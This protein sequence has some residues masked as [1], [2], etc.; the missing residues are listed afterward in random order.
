M[1]MG[2][3][4][5]IAELFQDEK[6]GATWFHRG[7]YNTLSSIATDFDGYLT[8]VRPYKKSDGIKEAEQLISTLYDPSVE[9]SWLK[10]KLGFGSTPHEYSFEL[11]FSEGKLRFIMKT[12]TSNEAQEL[13]KTIGGIYPHAQVKDSERHMPKIPEQSY[14]AGGEF[15]LKY[16]KYAPLR[17]FTGPDP[18]EVQKVEES[19]Q[20]GTVLIDPYK[21]VASELVGHKSEAVMLQITF[22]S[23]PLNWTDG[24]GPM[25]PSAERKAEYLK[26]G[27]SV[28]SLKN[29]RIIDPTEKDLRTAEH[30]TDLEDSQAFQCNIRYFVWDTSEESAIRRTQAIENI[31][32]NVYQNNKVAQ[33]FDPVRYSAKDV[34]DCVFDAARRK[35][36]RKGVILTKEEVA[37]LAHFPN[38]TIN[39]ANVDFVESVFGEQAPGD[40]ATATKDGVIESSPDELINSQYAEVNEHDPENGSDDSEGRK[41]P[42]D[43]AKELVETNSNRY[44]KSDRQPDEYVQT[45][46]TEDM[47][48]EPTTDFHELAAMFERGDIGYDYFY[49]E[50]ESDEKADEIIEWVETHIDESYLIQAYRVSQRQAEANGNKDSP[51]GSGVGEDENGDSDLIT[52]DDI[53][54][55]EDN[56]EY[57]PTTTER[58]KASSKANGSKA[59]TDGA[60]AT[61]NG[62][63][64]EEPEY[65][66]ARQQKH[67]V[68]FA[69]TEFR[70]TRSDS[71]DLL[72]M[73]FIQKDNTGTQYLGEDCRKLFIEGHREKKD[74]DIWLGYQEQ[75][76]NA[77]R[78]V[79]VPRSAWFQHISMFGTTGKGKSTLMK[80]MA[81][82]VAHKGHGFVIIDPKG[83]MAKDLMKE[84]PEDRLDDVIWVEPGSI[85]HDKIAA[86]NFLETSVPKDHPRYDRE[87]ES[88]VSD[89][90]AVLRAGEYWGPKMAGITK[91]ITRAMVRSEN[92]YTLY[93]MYNVLIREDKRWNFARS[94][95]RE[96]VDLGT[97]ESGDISE[98]VKQYSRRIAEMDDDEVDPVVR[99]LQ[100]WAESPISKEIVSHRYSTVSIDKA[101]NE[102]KIILVKNSVEDRE[103]KRVISTAIMRRVWVAIQA[104]AEATEEEADREPYFAF[105]DEFD[106]VV[107][108]DMEIDK[109]LSKAR[110]GRM[111]VTLATQNPSQ[112]KE[113]Y[114]NILKQIFNN[115]ETMVSFAVRDP[116]DGYL[117]SKR[118]GEDFDSTDM[119]N[120]PR[121]RVVTRVSYDGENGPQIS[122]PLGLRTFP[123]YP[124]LRTRSQ[125]KKAIKDSLD[126][127][128]VMPMDN[129]PGET[130]LLISGG[131]LQE[132]TVVNFLELVW[133]EH[134][135]SRSE[136]VEVEAVADRFEEIAGE[137]IEHYPNGIAIPEELIT[138]H[139]VNLDEDDS[140]DTGYF[141]EPEHFSDKPGGS[142]AKS[143]SEDV[144]ESN[145]GKIAYRSNGRI[146]IQKNE[147]QVSITPQGIDAVL[148][149]DTGRSQ[150][151]E[152]HREIIRQSIR[153]FSRI[154]FHTH[155]PVQ[156]GTNRV[157]DAQAD[158]PITDDIS[159]SEM[160]S[161]LDWFADT[162]P[163][164]AEFSQTSNINI[165]AE[166]TTQN[167]PA[168]TI[169]NVLRAKR[170]GRR[171][172]LFVKDGREDGHGRDF[173]AHRVENILTDPPYY[174]QKRYIPPGVDP[175]Q[176]D[177]D[178]DPDEI[179]FL[180]NKASKLK[181][182][183]PDENQDKFAL[184][185]AGSQTVWMDMGDHLNLYDGRGPDA[186]KRGEVKYSETEYASSNAMDIWCRYDNYQKEWV[187]YPGQ[188]KQFRY[189]S[190][191]AMEE[192]YQFVY[193]PLYMEAEV[194]ELPD[195]DSWDILILPDPTAITTDPNAPRDKD[196]NAEV[197]IEEKYKLD[198]CF[199]PEEVP[200]L[201]EDGKTTPLIPEEYD[202]LLTESR[203]DFS[204]SD[205]GDT[206]EQTDAS[207]VTTETPDITMDSFD[208]IEMEKR[209][210]EIIDGYKKQLSHEEKR[211]L[212]EF[213]QT[214]GAKNPGV[215]EFWRSVWDHYERDYDTGI[216]ETVLPDAIRSATGL[217]IDK[218]RDAVTIGKDFDLLIPDEPTEPLDIDLG[219]DDTIL[220]LVIP[221]ERPDLYVDDAEQFA[222]KRVWNEVWGYVFAE[223][224]ESLNQAELRSTIKTISAP[225]T[226]TQAD[227][228]IAVG[229]LSGAIQDQDT[230]YLLSGERPDEFWLDI[231]DHV[232]A[233]I[234]SALL[235]RKVFRGI[236]LETDLNRDEII[237][238]FDDAIEHNELY[239]PEHVDDDHYLINDPA[240]DDGPE[241][242]ERDEPRLPDD[243]TDDDPDSGTGRT[244]DAST[245]SDQA[246]HEEVGESSGQA[247]PETN[248]EEPDA[249]TDEPPEPSTPTASE[250]NTSESGDTGESE[251]ATTEATE[252]PT[253]ESSDQ[254]DPTHADEPETA[255]TEAAESPTEESSDQDDQTHTVESDAH[256]DT[257][258]GP[259]QSSVETDGGD[260][261]EILKSVAAENPPSEERVR[262]AFADGIEFFHS[263]LDEPINSNKQWNVDNPDA[264]QSQPETAREYFQHPRYD[265]GDTNPIQGFIN[266]KGLDTADL[267]NQVKSIS[268]TTRKEFNDF[269]PEQDTPP[270]LNSDP[271]GKGTDDA[272]M[273]MMP[274]AFQMRQSRGWSPEIIDKKKLGW[275][276]TDPNA[277]YD[278]LSEKG[279]TDK[280]LVATGLFYVNGAPARLTA[281]FTG[282]YVFPYFNAEGTPVYAI[283][284]SIDTSRDSFKSVDSTYNQKY[285]KTIKN[286]AYSMADE[287]IYG[288]ESVKEGQPVLITEGMADAISAHERGIPCISPV[289]R[290]FKTEH[291]DILKDIILEN[292]IPEV[293]IIQD[294]D[295]ALV[296]DKEQDDEADSISEVLKIGQYGSGM[297]GA[298]DT[299]RYLDKIAL[300]AHEATV[301][302][303]DEKT[304]SGGSGSA[305]E[306]GESSES[307]SVDNGA[308]TEAVPAHIQE[309]CEDDDQIEA[310]S[311]MV[312]EARSGTPSRA[313]KTYIIPLPRFG[314]IKYDLDDYLTDKFGI[315]T[316]PALW[317]ANNTI[318]G[319]QNAQWVNDL[320]ADRHFRYFTGD[321]YRALAD[322]DFENDYALPSA[323]ILNMLPTIAPR[324]LPPEAGSGKGSST[325]NVEDRPDKDW[326]SGSNL[327]DTNLFNIS[328]FDV[329][330]L[331]EGFRGKSPL[332]HIG[333]SENYFC[334]LEDDGAYCHK[335]D[336]WYNPAT[337]ILCLEGERPDDN[338]YGSFSDEEKFA[339]WEHVRNHRIKW[340]QIPNDALIYYAIR[341]GIATEDDVIEREGTYG[342]FNALRARKYHEVVDHLVEN[343][344]FE[345]VRDIKRREDEDEDE[346]T[347]DS[348]D[349]SD[350]PNYENRAPVEDDDMVNLR[351]V[352]DDKEAYDE[353]MEQYD[354]VG[355]ADGD[356]DDEGELTRFKTYKEPDLENDDVDV[357]RDAVKQFVDEFAEIGEEGDIQMKTAS[358]EMLDLFTTW[359]KI[360]DIELDKLSEDTADNF[361]KG[362]L[363]KSLSTLFDVEKVRARLDGE[364]MPLYRPIE[365]S[366]EIKEIRM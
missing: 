253:E 184:M 116:D 226:E 242:I 120:M 315:V 178:D 294:A 211:R 360:N 145:D 46:I 150:P 26:E 61:A 181:V 266:P 21:T 292:N 241:L 161:E 135:R 272:D 205:D 141:N 69:E 333:D 51:R 78:E 328:M 85:E 325:P 337:A 227:A 70:Q 214:F 334:V 68:K 160:Q 86:I 346:E 129:Y 128:G 66:P 143:D 53:E 247:E 282:R 363:K 341:E 348:V 338:P 339:L 96:D 235:K 196:K 230:G 52:L 101:V 102:G 12:P 37:A 218:A 155:L 336:A 269:I 111:S 163:L 172:T 356:E 301:A 259:S 302:H 168:R 297:D 300:D 239:S 212:Q 237:D 213:E 91:N 50:I 28:D 113:D 324:N 330:G 110:S 186:N 170:E 114:P 314:G 279:Y 79:G 232:G 312:D 103:I 223:P 255:T 124:P 158:I 90:Q 250:A 7:D 320:H 197:D 47:P 310:I 281:Q 97:S 33:Q 35:I 27:R 137:A 31:I 357:D 11:W 121:F 95:Q 23:V 340:A 254:E 321:N 15:E 117:I 246:T 73:N 354:Q 182:G 20:V 215:I 349:D 192:D 240:S 8:R 38:D 263:K 204:D 4:G 127:Y 353:T 5:I 220:R 201:Y 107:S 139:N 72:T 58:L 119:T 159:I 130:D 40:S 147:A 332:G 81:L 3:R 274:Y 83:D 25:D 200:L 164:A 54:A 249:E 224:D 30:I 221:E 100:D 142:G 243:D 257:N 84:L 75:G 199:P 131:G 206:D 234:D 45:S 14:V 88:I 327:G 308:S 125:A 352:I 296:H 216:P 342:K 157:C 364:K 64:S 229:V 6:Y 359:A 133:N 151:T 187:V 62:N 149:Q 162:Y 210:R 236:R 326:N 303:S 188:N 17:S 207:N 317:A 60:G 146:Y 251:A 222:D 132:Q 323:T 183:N 270:I 136:I 176:L 276:P 171:A 169:E 42:Y 295:P 59:A 1:N 49:S 94:L 366:D 261:A 319:E 13:Q 347:S 82:Q 108:D 252:S 57:L 10:K 87:V 335:R 153:W 355:S 331:S 41:S 189:E 154:G 305:E 99:R 256:V 48:P 275:A 299:A 231:W 365:L 123:D 71:G 74:M 203:A 177:D 278:H 106:D 65:L 361:R 350:E 173:H 198:F 273:L 358:N 217:T 32:T 244:D 19:E 209:A 16:T 56:P 43:K 260:S 283:S 233:E 284:R 167:K 22:S 248:Q 148:Q 228:A 195:E 140:Q 2:I 193:A 126:E 34:K 304:E 344:D 265:D 190:R 29:P 105:I 238:L 98:D 156:I 298:A 80:N 166:G 24:F 264:R 271:L 322:G 191:Q 311:E 174:R 318:E 309:L 289:T 268:G 245:D 287:P 134:H 109:M 144:E 118:M 93:D 277:L 185:D 165:E 122:P 175:S 225:E 307:E 39:T 219:D 202:D 76:N 152:S 343:Y 285:T 9:T 63:S 179:K 329:F 313:F 280:E 180:Y 67:P 92:P 258:S 362:E 44:Y 286:T 18:F 194:D 262:A 290:K 291:A 208:Q 351:N 345:I 138:V 36:N 115:T 55:A 288:L 293:Y 306:S 316:P 112:I 267:E 89:L 77:V 104:R